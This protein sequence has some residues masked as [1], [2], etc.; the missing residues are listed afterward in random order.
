VQVAQEIPFS[1]KTAQMLKATK[2]GKYTI[3]ALFQAQL[4]SVESYSTITHLFV[5]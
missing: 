4:Q 3:S 2:G 5:A 1:R